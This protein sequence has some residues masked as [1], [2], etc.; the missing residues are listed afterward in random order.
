MQKLES[1]VKKSK[2]HYAGILTK[3]EFVKTTGKS[4]KLLRSQGQI[5]SSA[6]YK[7]I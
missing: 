6:R 1:F 7:A 3:H 4:F 2:K 5:R